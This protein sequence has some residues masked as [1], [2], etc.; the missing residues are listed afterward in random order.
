[1]VS[2]VV[3]KIDDNHDEPQDRQLKF[4]FIQI[5]KMF[6]FYRSGLVSSRAVSCVNINT[7]LIR[8]DY[9]YEPPRCSPFH[10]PALPRLF[11]PTSAN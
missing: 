1:M 8:F 10:C 5:R 3:P 2:V 7:L 4:E 9:F 11:P 6:L